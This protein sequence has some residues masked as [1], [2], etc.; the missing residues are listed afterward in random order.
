MPV[1]KRAAAR[2]PSPRAEK[3]AKDAWFAELHQVSRAYLRQTRALSYRELCA[4]QDAP[5][6][7]I[8]F[9]AAGI[10][11]AHWRSGRGVEIAQRWLTEAARGS[12]TRGAFW[13]PN[14][15]NE[16][17][18]PSLYYGADGIQLLRLLARRGDD[19]ALRAFLARCRRCRGGPSELLQGVAGYLTALVVL[20]RISRE[21]RVLEVADELAHD[22]LERAGGR[23]GW[24]R[25]PKVGFAHGRAGTLH[26]LLGWSL[27]GGRELPAEL[28]G[29]LARLADDV[30]AMGAPSSSGGPWSKTLER[31]WCN[32]AAGLVLL[33]TRAYEH[34]SDAKYLR[35]ARDAARSLLTYTTGAPGDLCCGLGGRAYALL[36]MD[37]IA[38]GRGWFDRALA[39]ASGAAAAML[40]GCGPWPNGLFKGYPGLVCLTRDLSEAPTDRIGFPL[41]DGPYSATR[42]S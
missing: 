21:P 35:R 24:A 15:E 16:S 29:H 38:P 6:A 18:G 39:M 34:T 40:E 3:S 32:G 5:W 42:A 17:A 22:L 41:V 13:N 25:A 28:F 10:A 7:S 27:V 20:Y 37:R 33:W 19:R 12:R 23:R 1:T 8:A 14:F 2:V 9:G 30:E 36:A 4:N 26:A 31:S 11:A